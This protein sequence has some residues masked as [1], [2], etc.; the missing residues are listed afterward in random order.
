M[1]LKNL[2]GVSTDHITQKEDIIG[3]ITHLKNKNIQ[4]IGLRILKNSRHELK[5]SKIPVS[6]SYFDKKYVNNK[7]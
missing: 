7:Y 3:R 6:L 2:L 1:Y 4:I 5:N